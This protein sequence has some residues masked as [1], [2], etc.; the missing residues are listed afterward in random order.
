MYTTKPAHWSGH[1]DCHNQ[2]HDGIRLVHRLPLRLEFDHQIQMT[3]APLKYPTADAHFRHV[4]PQDKTRS[5]GKVQ[6]VREE[7]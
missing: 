3:E 5:A 1:D 6:G 4:H 7:I 2:P